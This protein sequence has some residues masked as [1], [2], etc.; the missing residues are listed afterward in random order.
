MIR[1]KEIFLFAH[2]LDSM[3]EYST[4]VPSDV[5][6]WKMWRRRELWVPKLARS[7]SLFYAS[8]LKAKGFEYDDVWYV[9]QYWPCQLHERC[10]G[11]HILW[12]KVVMRHGPAP[13][14]Y[15]EPDWTNY[16]RWERERKAA[17]AA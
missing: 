14:V 7:F 3:P 15:R 2:E 8:E 9:G 5:V 11:C 16:G 1:G 17:G 6:L 12:F 13:A 4:T 10:E